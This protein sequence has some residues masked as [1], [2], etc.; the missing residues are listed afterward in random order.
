MSAWVYFEYFPG[1]NMADVPE[2]YA[3]EFERLVRF[4]E[5][6]TA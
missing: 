3:L 2:N 6:L 5:T 4:F 1:A